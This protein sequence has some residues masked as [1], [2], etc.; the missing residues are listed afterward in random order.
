MLDDFSLVFAKYP[1]GK[2][3]SNY[4][5]VLIIDEARGKDGKTIL[6]SRESP[7]NRLP[8]DIEEFRQFLEPDLKIWRSVTPTS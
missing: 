8:F 7:T 5:W 3:D 4:R 6:N 1:E 2:K